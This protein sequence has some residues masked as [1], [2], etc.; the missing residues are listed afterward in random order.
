MAA[1]KSFRLSAPTAKDLD[2][3]EGAW[4]EQRIVHEVAAGSE[5]WRVLRAIS[6]S[7]PIEYAKVCHAS[8]ARNRFSPIVV[9]G[10]IV[11]AAYAGSS[12]EIALWEGV[13]RDIRHKAVKRV[14]QSEI[15]NRYL[16]ETRTT[17][18]LK[19]L[20]LRRPRD[21]NLVGGR[22][23]PPNLSAAPK[24]AY[25]ITREWAQQLYTRLPEI[26]GFIYESHQISGDCILLLQ[27]QDPIVFR[28]VGAARPV[29]EEPARSILR[30]EARKAGAV[31]DYGHLPDPPDT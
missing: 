6:P 16:I 18:A 3:A 9:G 22:R 14:P 30:A 29:S 31:V 19:L 25:S 8:D 13:L 10:K 7:D 2:A 4:R 12:R 5:F 21:A 1:T 17:R 28:P 27:P 20:D 26:D 15:T 23:R 24:S 11:P